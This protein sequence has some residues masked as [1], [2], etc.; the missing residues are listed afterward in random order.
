MMKVILIANISAN[1]QVLLAGNPAH[2]APQDALGFFV[3][4]ANT[5]ET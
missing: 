4:E 1:G 2:E 3:Q 5:K